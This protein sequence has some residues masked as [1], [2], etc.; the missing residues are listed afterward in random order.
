MLQPNTKVDVL[1]RVSDWQTKQIQEFW[2]SG[3]SIFD[4]ESGVEVPARKK[5]KYGEVL[6]VSEGN[7]RPIKKKIHEV[8]PHDPK[9]SKPFNFVYSCSM[10]ST[11]L[12]G[13]QNESEKDDLSIGFPAAVET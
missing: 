4:P 7:L 6:I 12:A 3:Y 2:I 5:T 8:R 11:H 1:H 13:I 9:T 10:G